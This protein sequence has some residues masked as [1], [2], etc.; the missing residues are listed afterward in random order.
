MLSYS[1][2][3][4]AR[5]IDGLAPEQAGS[6]MTILPPDRMLKIIRNLEPNFGKSVLNSLGNIVHHSKR[7]SSEV[8]EKFTQNIFDE[9]KMKFEED[10][11]YLQA[12][13]EVADQEE[14]E[15]ISQGLEFNAKLLLEVIG[16]RATID[17][18]W[19]QPIDVL[20][21]IF[22]LVELE[23]VTAMLFVSPDSVREGVMKLFPERKRILT[24]DA[25]E[26]MSKDDSYR[27]DL[28]KSVPTSKKIFLQKLSDM[29]AAGI[30]TLPSRTRL[31]ALAEEQ[32]QSAD[33]QAASDEPNSAQAS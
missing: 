3:D 15:V 21:G 26:N 11:K 27:E 24:E 18:L 25:L 10:R 6:M 8:L 5:A 13:V 1:D 32:E 23:P 7:T 19:A 17:D 4:V 30:V 12:I 14:L 9:K 2:E 22:S 20:E 28:L 33:F 31:M 29:A 16:V